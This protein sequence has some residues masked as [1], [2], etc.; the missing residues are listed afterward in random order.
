VELL[1]RG[2][3]EDLSRRCRA[4]AARLSQAADDTLEGRECALRAY[5][6]I[7]QARREALA[8]AG[9]PALSSPLLASDFLR[10]HRRLAEQVSA[11][12]GFVLPSVERF[13]DEDRFLTRLT[14]ALADEVRWPCQ[15][16]LVVAFSTHYYWT[17]LRYNIIAVPAGEARTLLGLPDLCHELAHALYAQSGTLL[18]DDFVDHIDSYIEDERNRLVAK[19]Q[20]R[21]FLIELDRLRARWIDTWV[22]EFVCDMVATYL[23]GAAF[24]G[25]HVRLAAGRATGAAFYPALGEDAVHPADEARL[26]GIALILDKVGD[27]SGAA[28]IRDTWR[29][30]ASTSGEAEPPNYAVCYPE[31]LIE[32]L[33][34]RVAAGCRSLGLRAFAD[35][36]ASDHAGIQASIVESWRQ[37]LRNPATH[38]EWEGAQMLRIS[39]GLKPPT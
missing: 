17:Y 28:V 12:E 30:Y 34:T 33:A 21:S 3:L 32:Q 5:R 1:L 2:L 37:F 18:V 38:G 19:Q 29:A 24:G 7:E 22:A 20:S 35:L 10:R 8:L 25:Q 9:D 15:H 6:E 39:E 36:G 23:V 11:I 31:Q 26:R 14:S 16:P 27:R 4:I 13:S